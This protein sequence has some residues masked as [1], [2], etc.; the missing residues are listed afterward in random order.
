MNSRNTNSVLG[1]FQAA[2]KMGTWYTGIGYEGREPNISNI[3]N[4]NIKW[5][6]TWA[7]VKIDNQVHLFGYKVQVSTFSMTLNVIVL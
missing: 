1:L 2:S 7:T 4:T 3:R 6:R 5:D